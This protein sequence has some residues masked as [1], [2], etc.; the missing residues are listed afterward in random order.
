MVVDAP[1]EAGLVTPEAVVLDL[2]VAN[3]GSRSLAY[4]IDVVVM[5]AIF[6]AVV[7]LA[8]L[9]GIDDATSGVILVVLLLFVLLFVWP[10]TFE[11]VSHGR[12]PGKMV[13]G[14]RVLTVEGGP[15]RM[16]HAAIR[17][18]LAVVEILACAGGV[19]VVLALFT[20]RAQ[21]LGDLVA[22]TVVVQA[23]APKRA[24]DAARFTPPPGLEAWTDSL[25]V[26]GLQEA[27]YEVV[28]ALVLR[29]ST[30]PDAERRRLAHD[31]SARL[32]ERISPPPPSGTDP[33]ALLTAVAA[34]YQ[35]RFAARRDRDVS[36][37]V[38]QPDDLG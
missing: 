6:L 4:A 23:R 31:V 24:L 35:R 14:L 28:R 8:D 20:R 13:L 21:R 10:T 7:M 33:V 19:A 18:A 11:T 29:E 9:V 3:V 1:G 22:G 17:S 25:D 38:W 36:A 30:L 12:S 16:R 32:R 37:W 15:V 26:T 27:D 2:P 5:F 34:A